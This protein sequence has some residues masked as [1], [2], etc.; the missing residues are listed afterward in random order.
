MSRSVD[1]RPE[2]FPKGLTSF[3]SLSG[4]RSAVLG[5]GN[6]LTPIRTGSGYPL[7]IYCLDINI[8]LF[9]VL[10]YRDFFLSLSSPFLLEIPRSL[11][12]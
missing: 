4:R 5:N 8:V 2:V 6:Y 11:L 9:L 12:W 1:L 10:I 7:L 3:L